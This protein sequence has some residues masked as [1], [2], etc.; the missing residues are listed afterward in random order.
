MEKDLK[1]H[2]VIW[3]SFTDLLT[4]E[5][6][7]SLQ[8]LPWKQLWH[9]TVVESMEHEIFAFCNI[10]FTIL[11]I[12]CL[13]LWCQVEDKTNQPRYDWGWELIMDWLEWGE[14]KGKG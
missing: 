9:T 7:G 2:C 14:T 13:N 12:G 6:K 3:N 5:W 10:I 8:N 11:F 4:L 1:Y